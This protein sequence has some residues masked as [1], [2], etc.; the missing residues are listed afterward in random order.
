MSETSPGQPWPDFQPTA[1]LEAL[2]RHGVDFVVIGGVAAIAHGSARLTQDLDI[3]YARDS[4]NLKALGEALIELGA[5]LRGV[6]EDVAF[7]PDHTTLRHTTILTLDTSAGPIDLLAD[8]A[9][10]PPYD[11]LRRN[12]TRIMLGATPIL[13]ASIDDLVAMKLKAGRTKDF[14]DIEELETIRRLSA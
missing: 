9:G 2:A 6:D 13:I 7:V 4:D 10:A 5:R 8:P 12:A 3:A 11:G 1:L 14:A